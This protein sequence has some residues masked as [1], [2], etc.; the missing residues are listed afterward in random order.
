[1][2]R[3]LATLLAVLALLGSPAVR[4]Q[5]AA[6][7]K[8]P[9]IGLALS[10]GGVRG[11]AHIGVLEWFEEHRI[12]VDYIAGTSFGG[13]VGGM[14][15]IGMTP[16]EMRQLINSIDW[17]NVLRGTPAF[18][19]L[20]F[21]R[22]QDRRSF[23][24]AIE[25]GLK[26]GLSGATGLNP[27]HQIGLFLDRLALPYGGLNNFDELPIP[28]RC[29]A[30][31]MVAAKPVILKDG[32]FSQALRATMAFPGLFTPVERDGKVLAD[33]GLMNN[34]PT[35]IV[36][37]MGAE[38][39]IAVD[40]GTPLGNRKAVESFLGLLQQSIGVMTIEND[41]R[42][43]R[44]ADLVVS[45]DLDQYGLL[46][47]NAAK[48]ITERGYDGAA[49]RALMLNKLALDDAAWQ[50]HLVERNSRKRSRT[51]VPSALEITGTRI[52]DAQAIRNK[53]EGYIG[54]P[55]APERLQADLT[56]IT[57]RGRDES[58]G[59]EIRRDKQQETLLIRVKQKQYG[60]PFVNLNL[61]IEGS[62]ANNID[63]SIGGRVTLFEVGSYRSE[64]RTDFRLGSRTLLATE[65]YRPLGESGLFVAPRAR[66]ERGTQDLFMNG[67]RVAEYQVKRV[68]AG[69]DIGYTFRRSELR[70]G[71][72]LGNINARVRVG[73]PLLP[74]LKGKVSDVSARYEFDGQDSAVV[75]SRGVRLRAEAHRFFA[76]PGA[77]SDFSQ[78]E[79]NLSAFKP[80]TERGSVFVIGAGGTTFAQDAPPEQQFAL[81][82]PLRLGALG[83]GELRGNH[84][85]LSG[86]GYLHALAKLPPLL[87][88]KVYASSWYE[89][90]GA[91]Q[92][93]AS[94]R[95]FN[96]I[97]G[98]VVV[99]TR[100]GPVALGGSLGEGGRA[101]LYFSFGRFF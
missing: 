14:Y 54:K 50:Q 4:G 46:D 19:R 53:L 38:L 70:F 37:Q 55:L 67:A 74:A 31:D 58:L 51:P 65:Y 95:F 5:V 93:I 72:D 35:D 60:P 30:T 73:D 10:G 91:F 83:R 99:V 61:E 49:Q 33:G 56:E 16:A 90:G 24:N 57:G 40:I 13:L 87:G 78:A 92:N 20:S 47:F 15:A 62:D 81:G 64:W 29:V 42:N 101:R 32:S 26:N 76:S 7:K 98:G 8:R 63:T 43:L 27:G 12:P 68:G 44:L 34:I 2:R 59:Y 39:V 9:K 6:E 71:Y 69:V 75:P 77:T 41:R 79:V 3:W 66:Y 89:V 28:F 25:L 84:Y 22:K 97:S 94:A 18:E 1:M 82:G 11:L 96:N 85:L 45:P 21:R 23:Q 100:F 36:K 52:E 86:L 48:A 17:D 80:I 88:G